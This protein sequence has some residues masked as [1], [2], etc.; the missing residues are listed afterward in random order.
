MQGLLAGDKPLSDL[1][2]HVSV[3]FVA[4][5]SLARD[6]PLSDLESHGSVSSV[7]RG[8]L[9]SVRDSKPENKSSPAN[10]PFATDETDL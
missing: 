3:S 5:G 10:E 9:A 4:R 6:G 8:S 7:V 2:S 1:E